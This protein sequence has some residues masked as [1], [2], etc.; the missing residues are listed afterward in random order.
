M[1]SNYMQKNITYLLCNYTVVWD[2]WLFIGHVMTH[3]VGHG[4][5]ENIRPTAW[6][7]FIDFPIFPFKSVRLVICNECMMNDW[8]PGLVFTV[9]Q[10]AFFKVKRKHLGR[11]GILI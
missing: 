6:P 11:D 4:T 3:A 9:L 2:G 5:Y 10:S 8:L 7:E 1:E